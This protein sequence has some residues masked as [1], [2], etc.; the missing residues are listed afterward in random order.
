M[1]LQILRRFA[2]SVNVFGVGK[3]KWMR[4]NRLTMSGLIYPES[5]SNYKER[6]VEMKNLNSVR[7]VLVVVAILGMVGLLSANQ[8]S[9]SRTKDCARGGLLHL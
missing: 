4:Y 6:S 8:T 2:G 7:R 3:G 1:T 9:N 5:I